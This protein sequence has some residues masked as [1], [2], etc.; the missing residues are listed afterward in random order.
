MARM[1]PDRGPRRGSG[2]RP[3]PEQRRGEPR[4]T[5]ATE[6]APGPARLLFTRLLRDGAIW[7]VYVATSGDGASRTQLEFESTGRRCTRP[8]DG[9]LLAALHSGAPVSRSSLLDELEL[10]LAGEPAAGA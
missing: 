8:V 7:S 9:P 6:G 10:A 2:G 1:G 3:S 4:R 5:A